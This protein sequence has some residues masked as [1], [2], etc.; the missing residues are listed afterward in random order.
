MRYNKQVWIRWL[1]KVN[2]RFE[3]NVLLGLFPHPE[4][5]KYANLKQENMPRN[6]EKTV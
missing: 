5:R 1:L 3:F 6:D 2:S 4:T